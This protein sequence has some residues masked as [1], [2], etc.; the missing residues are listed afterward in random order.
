MSPKSSPVLSW[1]V[2]RRPE[3]SPVGDQGLRSTCLAWAATAAHEAHVLDGLS[4]EFLHWACDPPPGGRGTIAGLASALGNKGQ[5]PA[6][7]WPYDASIDDRAPTYAPPSSVTGPFSA[8]AIRFIDVTPESLVAELVDGRLPVAGLR[9]TPAFLA[10]RGGIVHGSDT[11]TDGHAITVVGIAETT[12]AVGTIP[13]GE[14]LV[15]VR[16][17]WG[18]T[19]GSAG[20]ALVTRTAWVA[21]TLLALVL[22]PLTP[23]SQHGST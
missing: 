11:G 13:T 7:Q 8:A 19:W 18:P 22:E 21:C 12:H 17:S 16:N 6:D 23:K 1:I 20:L 15:C 9:V 4:V 2:D 3:I 14:R 5:P 10:A